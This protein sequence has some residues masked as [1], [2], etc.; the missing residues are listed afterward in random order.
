MMWDRWKKL[1]RAFYNSE[2]DQF[3]ISKIP[4]IYDSIKFD[5]IHNSHLRCDYSKVR[6]AR[7]LAVS[8]VGTLKHAPVN[9][10]LALYRRLRSWHTV[11][12]T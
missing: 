12:N 9:L 7:L 1:E 11:F 4:D 3:D 10:N 8:R 5:C 6:A 2:A